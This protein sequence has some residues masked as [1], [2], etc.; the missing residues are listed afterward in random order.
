MHRLSY[1]ETSPGNDFDKLLG[2]NVR[3][4]IAPAQFITDIPK[5]LSGPPVGP[6]VRDK[7]DTASLSFDKIFFFSS[8]ENVGV[9]A[10]LESHA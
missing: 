6:D 1:H 10:F 3:G 2:R 8:C 5:G 9:F 7:H 4:Q